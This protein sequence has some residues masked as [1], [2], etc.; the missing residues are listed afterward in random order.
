MHRV[1]EQ[2]VQELARRQV[3]RLVHAVAQRACEQ[4]PVAVL[5]PPSDVVEHR[6]GVLAERPGVALHLLGERARNVVAALYGRVRL[7]AGVGDAGGQPPGCPVVRDDDRHRERDDGEFGRAD[8]VPAGGESAARERCRTPCRIAASA[9]D[10][11]R[12]GG[13]GAHWSL[14]NTLSSASPCFPG[15]SGALMCARKTRST[16]TLC[17]SRYSLREAADAGGT[18]LAV[19]TLAAA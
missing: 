2:L 19:R 17:G 1:L 5:R 10:S 14:M 6:R 13:V 16:S 7:L 9:H 11:T 8:V 12:T 18:V 3:H 15:A 4:V